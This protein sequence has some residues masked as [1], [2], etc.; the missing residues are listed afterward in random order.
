MTC[1]HKRRPGTRSLQV[2]F[3]VTAQFVDGSIVV[4]ERPVTLIGFL[5]YSFNAP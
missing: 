2:L 3:K 4:P 5:E 1:R